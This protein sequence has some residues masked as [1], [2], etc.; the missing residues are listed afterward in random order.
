[1]SAG[2]I[3]PRLVAVWVLVAALIG[4]IVVVELKERASEELEMVGLGGRER[5]LLS[6]SADHVGALEVVAAGAMHR[7]ERDPAGT[8][9]YHEAHAKVDGVHGHRNDPAL[10]ET[11]ANAVRAFGSA[12]REREFRLDPAENTFGVTTPS[13]VILA[14]RP[15]E[16][17][18]MAQF[19]VGDLA[20]D[21]VSRY[22]LLVGSDHVVSLA[23]YQ[24]ENLS[25]LVETA[26]ASAAAAAAAA[27][28]Q[29]PGAVPTTPTGTQPA[30]AATPAKA[31]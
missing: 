6:E 21:G 27:V 4:V 5:M 1:M 31:P 3:R 14:Y 9:Y 13:M 19:A 7:F 22:V 17:Q 8:W 12:R 23:G 26:K 28:Q 10:A 30:P 24:I 2:R 29:A 20:P 16:T 18:P 25:K 15:N 11:I